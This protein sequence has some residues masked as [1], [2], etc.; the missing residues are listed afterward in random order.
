MSTKNAFAHHPGKGPQFYRIMLGRP[1]E[2]AQFVFIEKAVLPNELRSGG[3][4]RSKVRSF[5]T[6][7]QIMYC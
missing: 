5:T 3:T 1:D 7:S 4:I 6:Q 2:E